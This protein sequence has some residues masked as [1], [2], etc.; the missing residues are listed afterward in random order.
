MNTSYQTGLSHLSR[1]LPSRLS[2]G[3]FHLPQRPLLAEQDKYTLDG[4]PEKEKLVKT[5]RFQGVFSKALSTVSERHLPA[6]SQT[7]L[8][9]SA[10]VLAGCQQET[11]FS[12][13]PTWVGGFAAVSFLTTWFVSSLLASSHVLLSQRSSSEKIAWTVASWVPFLG[14][15]LWASLGIEPHLPTTKNKDVHFWEDR[16]FAKPEDQVSPD[17]V[18]E[19]LPEYFQPMLALSRNVTGN[20]LVANNSAKPLYNGEEA[21]PEMLKAIEEEPAGG[22]VYLGYYIFENNETGKKFAH[23]LQRAQ[24]RGV[25]VRVI[26]DRY[27]RFI[28]YGSSSIQTG[29]AYLRELGLHVEIFSPQISIRTGLPLNYTYHAKYLVTSQMAFVGGINIG[30]TYLAERIENE[31]RHK[32]IQF[33]LRGPIVSEVL[34]IFQDHWAMVSDEPLPDIAVKT[35]RQGASFQRTIPSEPN[36]NYENFKKIVLGALRHARKKV[37]IMTGYFLPDDELKSA[38]ILAAKS[39]VDVEI[40]LSGKSHVAPVDWAARMH[41]KELLYG[42]VKIYYQPPP[43][44]HTKLLVA[45]DF[46]VLDGSSNLDQRSLK[47]HFE[48]NTENYDRDLAADVSRHFDAIKEQ[49]QEVTLEWVNQWPLFERIKYGLSDFFSSLY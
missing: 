36:H 24:A 40:I 11:I 14:P 39:G 15:L 1:F 27:G 30:D 7:T 9:L 44:D 29:A 13:L 35:E 46:Y 25:D 37:R 34:K 3:S 20:P 48:V 42:G 31:K 22:L 17:E 38:M 6:L 43:F 41:F 28:N 33:Q 23:A 19:G 16:Y 21:Y 4:T 8:L 18:P 2:Q 26:V 45:D 10:G 12:Q 49:S 5:E 47:W 32:D